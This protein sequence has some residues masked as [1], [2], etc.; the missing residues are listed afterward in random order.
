M[1]S[2][3]APRAGGDILGHII[4]ALGNNFNPRPPC[5]GRPNWGTLSRSGRT[6]QSTPPVRGATSGLGVSPAFSQ[7]Q[8]TPPV[9]GATS[10]SPA[11]VPSGI[12]FQS[13]P[14]VRGATSHSRNQASTV[15]IS[16]HAP[17]A[18]G[19]DGR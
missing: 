11:L 8:S 1:I 18:G 5:G 17:R 19:D 12:R 9:R 6:F 15:M 4:Q 2:I 7:F 10:M 16:I 13:T 3:H 14:P